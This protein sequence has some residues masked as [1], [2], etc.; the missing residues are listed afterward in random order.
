MPVEVLPE[1]RPVFVQLDC[2]VVKQPACFEFM[3]G[4]CP[5][6][7]VLLS[8]T[9]KFPSKEGKKFEKERLLVRPQKGDQ[10]SAQQ[11]STASLREK[12]KKFTILFTKHCDSDD[13]RTKIFMALLSSTGG[14]IKLKQ[15]FK[16][17]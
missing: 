14:R 17:E 4:D 7:T 16:A 8:H 2:G 6:L 10:L 9:H 11:E 5:D 15:E 1:F 13:E 3:L 12:D